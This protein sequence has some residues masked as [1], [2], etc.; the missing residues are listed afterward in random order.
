MAISRFMSVIIS[1]ETLVPHPLTPLNLKNCHPHTEDAYY[2]LWIH[3][4]FQVSCC[5]R[6]GQVTI[7]D[8]KETEESPI[9]A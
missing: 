4:I 3:Y 5:F 7:L 9:D 6:L 2:V 1:Q 8:G